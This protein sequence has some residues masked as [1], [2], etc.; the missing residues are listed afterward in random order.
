MLN[1]YHINPNLF[2][3]LESV[4]ESEIET[5]WKYPNILVEKRLNIKLSKICFSSEYDETSLSLS[6]ETQR[7]H[8]T[9]PGQHI[10]SEENKTMAYFTE[11]YC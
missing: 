3:K 5:M 8:E 1:K 7:L 4:S 10:L 11:D 6:L 9:L 2:S